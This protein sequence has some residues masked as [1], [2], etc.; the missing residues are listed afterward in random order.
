M[1]KLAQTDWKEDVKAVAKIMHKEDAAKKWL[2][3]YEK[4][5]A[6]K[7]KEIKKVMGDD[8]TYLSILASG[9]QIFVYDKA[10][11]GSILYDDMGLK[12]PKGLPKQKDISLPVVSYEGLASIEADYILAVGTKDDMAA[13]K[14]NS[15]WKQL[16]AVNQ[17]HVTE[18]PAS[19]YFNQGYSSIGRLAF[20]DEMNGLME[21]MN[22]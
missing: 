3:Q 12:R 11:I 2:D 19:P 16:R 6:E 10:G 7:G 4:K 9:G 5:A 14:K 21:K 13:L 1:L 22:D 20:L 17:G 8:K 18:L 15:V